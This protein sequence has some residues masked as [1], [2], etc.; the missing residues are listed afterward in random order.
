MTSHHPTAFMSRRGFL[1]GAGGVAALGILAAACGSNTGRSPGGNGKVALAQ[2]YHQYGEAGTKEAA[3]RYAKAYPDASVT[4]QWTP[5]DYGSK[6]AS[7]LLSDKGPDVFESQLNI[8]M[9]QS[10]QVVALDDIM[11]DVKDDFNENDITTNTV[12]GK[13]YGVRMID[14]PQLIYYRKSLLDKA[15]LKP[16]TTVDDLIET[17]KALT[18]DKMKGIFVGNDGGLALGGPALWSSGG[19]FLTPERSPNF[20]GPRAAQAFSKLRELHTSKALLLGAPTDWWDPGALINELAAMQWIGLWAMPAIQKKFGD[21]IGVIAF[22]KLDAQG[23]DAVY[24]GGWTQFV[25]AKSKNVEAAKKFVRW[26]WIDKAEFQEDWCLSYGFHIPPR[27]SLAA[28]ASKLQAG[29]AADAVRLAADYGNT[30]NPAWTPK[31]GS[32]FGDMLTNVIKKGADPATELPKAEK[33]VQTELDR[34]FG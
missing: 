21:D 28:K 10:K 33:T 6:L 31:M 3:L 18:T 20:A 9:V 30:D 12:D 7:G 11:E 17:A 14:D 27:K 19:S 13:I 22:P 32:A 8:A 1:R 25:S 2:W 29:P 23:K 4:V 15:G 16:P 24:S 34:L 5:G 26:L